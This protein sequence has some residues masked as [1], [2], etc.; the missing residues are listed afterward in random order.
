MKILVQAH[1]AAREVKVA[2]IAPNTFGVWVTEPPVKGQANMGIIRALA[3]YFKIAPNQVQII[4]G[5]TSR[6]KL[7]EIFGLKSK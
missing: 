4:S 3:D 7:V 2:E 1:P 5:R 6:R